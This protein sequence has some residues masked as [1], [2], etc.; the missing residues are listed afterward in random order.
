MC[1]DGIVI[2]TEVPLIGEC[3]GGYGR[4]V[5]EGEGVVGEALCIV[6]DREVDGRF[7]VNGYVDFGGIG[8]VVAVGSDGCYGKCSCLWE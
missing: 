6:I 1:C 3:T 8:A 2:V 7:R 4:S 5:G